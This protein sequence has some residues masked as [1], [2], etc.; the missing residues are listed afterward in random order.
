[1]ATFIACQELR[2]AF[3]VNPP[4]INCDRW[5]SQSGTG[6]HSKF[7]FSFF[8]L[9]QRKTV[10]HD[11]YVCEC[12]STCQCIQI[13]D[14]DQSSYLTSLYASCPSNGDREYLIQNSVNGPHSETYMKLE[15]E[16][17]NWSALKKIA[18]CLPSLCYLPGFG[19]I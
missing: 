19:C 10:N 2:Q 6:R 18:T 15:K 12:A 11:G 9:E 13:E 4:S 17:E 1:M 14:I 3:R 16:T 7:S 5:F 8:L